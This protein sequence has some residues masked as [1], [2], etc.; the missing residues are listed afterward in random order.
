ME[1]L[2]DLFNFKLDEEVFILSIVFVA[3][4]LVAITVSFLLI[5]IKSPVK[6]RLDTIRKEAEGNVLK[7]SNRLDS[8]LGSL[9]PVMTPKSRKE[10]ETVRYHL[11]HAG[12]HQDNAM[13]I[14][15]GIKVFSVAIG[16]LMAT[17]LYLLSPEMNNLLLIMVMLVAAGM[18]V[19]NVFLDRLIKKRQRRIRAGVPDALDLL[20][21]CTE[22]GLGFS[23][24]LK[25][26]ADELMLS[27]PDFAE[28]LDMVCV[29]INAGVEMVDAFEELVRRTGVDDISGLVHMLAHATR[30]GG[31]IAQTLREYTEDYRDRRNQEVEEI[32]AKIPTKMI[33]PLLVC[34]W[35]CF[36]IVAVGPS[37]LFLTATLGK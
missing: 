20:V 1:Q 37:I 3:T 18:Y 7:K 16:V 23:A 8:A 4:T 30:I 22:S 28:E 29:K 14:Y 17:A 15:F 19:P 13:T 26:V 24:S 6:S 27:H 36:F 2:F 25:R 5:G 12:F 9:A 10:R 11:M 31:S 33:F 34:I 35:P 32:A 21:V